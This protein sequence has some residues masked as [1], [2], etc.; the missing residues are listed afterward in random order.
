[1]KCYKERIWRSQSDNDWVLEKEREWTTTR[2]E[3]EKVRVLLI[4][5]LWERKR[6]R[7]K[8]LRESAS[9]RRDNLNG[10]NEP[11]LRLRERIRGKKERVHAENKKN[12]KEQK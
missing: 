3:K 10:W 5:S 12:T 1:M 4:T 8:H 7:V 11:R 2:G 6:E 9:E